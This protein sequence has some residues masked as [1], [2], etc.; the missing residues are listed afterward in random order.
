MLTPAPPSDPI[1]TTPSSPPVDQNQAYFDFFSVSGHGFYLYPRS[2]DEAKQLFDRYCQIVCAAIAENIT[3]PNPNYIDKAN[4]SVIYAINHPEVFQS[5]EDH[6][7]FLHFIGLVFAQPTFVISWSHGAPDTGG[8][9]TL[10]S[11]GCVNL[12]VRIPP[13]GGR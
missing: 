2:L 11:S 10:P 8:I 1:N 4:A 3:F 13:L 6:D 7:M 9:I 12:R 5:Q